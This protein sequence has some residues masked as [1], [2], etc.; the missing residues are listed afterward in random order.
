MAGEA[1]AVRRRGHA[2]RALMLAMAGGAGVIPHDIGLMKFVAR[3]TRQARFVKAR[4][5]AD[6]NLMQPVGF[7]RSGLGRESSVHP[8]AQIALRAGVTGR[9]PVTAGTRLR[10]GGKNHSVVAR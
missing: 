10:R 4:H 9:A 2:T 7:Q 6:G 5:C 1:L 3:M 8:V